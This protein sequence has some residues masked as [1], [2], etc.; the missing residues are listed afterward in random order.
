M[1]SGL[2]VNEETREKCVGRSKGIRGTWAW[3]W[4]HEKPPHPTHQSTVSMQCTVTWSWCNVTL[5]EELMG[6]ISASS[7]FPPETTT[8]AVSS[9]YSPRPL[10]LQTQSSGGPATSSIFLSPPRYSCGRLLGTTCLCG[11]WSTP[12][13]CPPRGAQVLTM[14]QRIPI[15]TAPFCPVLQ[16]PPSTARSPESLRS[17]HPTEGA[18]SS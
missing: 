7:R 1:A 4:S 17:G 8:E 18:H 2:C 14:S 5:S 11:W 10:S 16:A 9:W 15:R 3:L 6:R 13:A 12:L